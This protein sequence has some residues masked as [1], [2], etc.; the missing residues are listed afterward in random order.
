MPDAQVAFDPTQVLGQTGDIFPTARV[1]D[2]YRSPQ[3]KTYRYGKFDNG[4]GNI[5]AVAGQAAYLRDGTANNFT[6]TSDQSDGFAAAATELSFCVG[7]FL[8]AIT[9]GRYGWL[10][11]GGYNPS[12]KVSATGAAGQRLLVSSTDGELTTVATGSVT[13]AQAGA[14]L[15]GLQYAPAVAGFAPAYLL[16]RE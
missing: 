13:A 9:D 3:G 2:I 1:G 7:V 14:P 5:A 15:V 4:S 10:Q 12:V 11:C 16:V 6:F 8:Y